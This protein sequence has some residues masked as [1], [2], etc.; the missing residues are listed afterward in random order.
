MFHILSCPPVDG[1][2]DCFYFLVV[3][4]NTGM[5]ICVGV[6]LH[7]LSIIIFTPFIKD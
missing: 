7:I 4:T 1:H 6:F 5:N 3:V 2:F